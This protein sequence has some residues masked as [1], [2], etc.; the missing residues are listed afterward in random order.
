MT[1]TWTKKKPT[2]IGWY[3]RRNE[4]MKEV[5]IVYLRRYDGELCIMNWRITT[6]GM[7]WAGPIPE[8]KE[9]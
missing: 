6:A 4:A 9:R 5:S 2:K 7:E 8:P 3:W 1:F